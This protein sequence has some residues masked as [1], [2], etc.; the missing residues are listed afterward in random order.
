M[1]TNLHT[2]HL[3]IFAHFSNDHLSAAEQELKIIFPWE[4]N[5]GVCIS[6]IQD[7]PKSC[8]QLHGHV[9]FYNMVINYTNEIVYHSVL[10]I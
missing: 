5:N 2:N 9:S 6:Y 1:L 10:S 4:H 3:F 8:I 7:V